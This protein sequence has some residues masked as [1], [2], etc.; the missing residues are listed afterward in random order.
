[1]AQVKVNLPRPHAAQQSC[2]AGARRF[3][4]VC[5]GEQAGRTTLGI[6]VLLASDYGA[7]STTRDK[8]PVAWFS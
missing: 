7:L 1:M 8:R 3:N 6:E 2:I 5:T 4:I